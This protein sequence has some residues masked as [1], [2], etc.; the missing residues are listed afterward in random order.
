M[1]RGTAWLDT[2]DARLASPMLGQF[3]QT[4]RT[5]P[6]LKIA[7]LEEIS[8]RLGYITGRSTSRSLANPVRKSGYGQ[9]LLALGANEPKFLA[10]SRPSQRRS[11]VPLWPGVL[12]F[13]PTIDRETVAGRSGKPGIKEVAWRRRGLPSTWVQDNS[14]CPPKNVVR[15]IHFQVTQ[16]QGKLVRVTHMAPCSM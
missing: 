8:Y 1:S 10:G 12:V 11:T 5:P 16:T 6:R 14:P 13:S 7:C 4:I 3:V 2:G 9:H 15:G